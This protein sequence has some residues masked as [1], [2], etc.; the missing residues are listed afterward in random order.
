[1]EYLNN[2]I[3]LK[4]VSCAVSDISIFTCRKM[5]SKNIYLACLMMVSMTSESMARGVRT[6][7]P[8]TEEF[9][10]FQRICDVFADERSVFDA[11]KEINGNVQTFQIN[12]EE[13]T[14]TFMDE[15]TSILED[16]ITSV[17]EAMNADNFIA[18][19]NAKVK[20]KHRRIWI[21]EKRYITYNTRRII[22]F[23]KI[24]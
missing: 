7:R 6:L 21:P 19:G 8:F 23:E 2:P 16:V 15:Q 18:T 22:L 20:N 11:R 17:C 13:T 1:M 4:Q 14:K 5:N 12:V 10:Q 9:D 3:T 24:R